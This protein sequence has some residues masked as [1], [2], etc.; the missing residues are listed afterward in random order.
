MSWTSRRHLRQTIEDL[1]RLRGTGGNHAFYLSIPP[2]FF[3]NVIGQ[4]KEHGLAEVATSQHLVFAG[5]RA[6]EFEQRSQ[7]E[8]PEK[9]DTVWRR[10]NR[11]QLGQEWFGQYWW[12]RHSR[13][14]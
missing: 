2:R 1:D 12:L 13:Q 10:F 14:N 6:G 5:N 4:L 3:G 11:H 8:Q 9:N 7:D